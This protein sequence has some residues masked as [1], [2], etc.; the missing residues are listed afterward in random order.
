[1]MATD[2]AHQS[3]H[4]KLHEEHYNQLKRTS[5]DVSQSENNL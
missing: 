2:A 5:H 1:M 3:Y 4:L